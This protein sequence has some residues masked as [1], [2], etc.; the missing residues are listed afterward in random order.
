LFANP[1]SYEVKLED[2]IDDILSVEL[3]SADVTLSAYLINSYFNKI[4]FSLSNTTTYTATLDIGDYDKS[5]LA[6][7]MESKL[8]DQVATNFQVTYNSTKD[9]F[10]FASKAA[11]SLDFTSKNSLAPLLGFRSKVYS[12]SATGSGTFPH[13]IN[14]EFRCNLK[15]NNYIV[16]NVDQ[17]DINKSNSVILQKTFAILGQSY[18][19][20]SIANNPRIV[21]Y[22]TPPIPRLLKLKLTFYDR[23]GN[24]YDFQNID[25]RIELQ[26]VSHKQKRKY[27]NIFL[28]R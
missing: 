26:F 14:A 5:S 6:T 16:L 25:H 20:L 17:F 28:N 4:I 10:T 19:D 12:S 24:L 2:D 15:Y 18:N 21:K 1:N 7:T 8:N 3:L 9:N 22:F 23:F 27:Q 13:I 11:F